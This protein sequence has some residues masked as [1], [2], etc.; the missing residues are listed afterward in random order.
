MNVLVTAASRHG[1]T[2]EIA[3]AIGRTLSDRG[4]AASVV[5][6]ADVTD[7][8]G[9]DAVIVGSAVYMGHWLESAQMFVEQHSEPLSSRPTWL[10]SSGPIGDPPRPKEPEAVDV[11]EIV[12]NTQAKEHHL[13]AGR[14]DKSKSGSGN[15]LSCSPSE[16]SKATTA[17][18]TRSKR[19]PA[20]SRRSS[21]RDRHHG[22]RKSRRQC[23]RR[24]PIRRPPVTAPVAPGLGG[25]G[26]RPT[27]D[28]CG[29]RRPLNGGAG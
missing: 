29:L 26:K 4:V 6:I 17:T 20:A 22:T 18:G 27:I 28:I 16:P 15:A 5:P 10:F 13:F 9:Y 2:Q 14:V 23:D 25:N 11:D 1:S 21:G 19:G 12:A 7:L 8:D 3:E 24:D